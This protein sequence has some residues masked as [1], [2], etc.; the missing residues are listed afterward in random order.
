MAPTTQARVECFPVHSPSS[1]TRYDAMRA[2]A[3]RQI[4]RVLRSSSDAEDLVQSVLRAQLA[5]KDTKATT[6]SLVYRIRMKAIDKRRRLRFRWS[7]LRTRHLAGSDSGTR[8][9]DAADE[10]MCLARQVRSL[11]AEQRQVLALLSRG[12]T[13]ASIAQAAGLTVDQVRTRVLRATLSLRN[14]IGQAS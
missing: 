7:M 8:R 5:A 6:K 9:V 13:Y 4:G 12:L 2:A 14:E 10:S 3:R 1:M 11:P